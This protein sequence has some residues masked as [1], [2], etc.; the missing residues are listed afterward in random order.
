MA[1]YERVGFGAVMGVVDLGVG[2]FGWRCEG[3]EWPSERVGFGCGE[4]WLE[5]SR[6]G[7]ANCGS[8]GF[9]GVTGAVVRQYILVISTQLRCT[10]PTSQSPFHI[11]PRLLYK[12][13][14]GRGKGKRGGG[15]R[16]GGRGI[17]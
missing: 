8:Q 3:A 9:G 5:V 13:E 2:K 15:G 11:V 6:G 10:V 1:E 16:S 12:R 14:S 7:V 4:L 17:R